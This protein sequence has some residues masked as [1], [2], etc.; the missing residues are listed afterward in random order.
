MS[1]SLPQSWE[2]FWREVVKPAGIRDERDLERLR[3]AFFAGAARA[4]DLIAAGSGAQVSADID[5]YCTQV[6]RRRD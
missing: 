3:D 5:E 4:A 2:E 6:E 1:Q